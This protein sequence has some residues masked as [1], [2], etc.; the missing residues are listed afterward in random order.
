MPNDDFYTYELPAAER[1]AMLRRA[2]EA[3]GET[4]EQV[5]AALNIDPEDVLEVEQEAWYMG[6][7]EEE[8][9][10]RYGVELEQFFFGDRDVPVVHRIAFLR[11]ELAMHEQA[12][13]DWQSWSGDLMPEHV[14]AE[15]IDLHHGWAEHLMEEIARRQL[16]LAL[17]PGT[18]IATAADAT[19]A[20]APELP[21]VSLTL[22]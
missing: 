16:E 9:G 8:L 7:P 6:S 10:A 14:A 18:P 4:V 13:L 20:A 19:P 15:W 5:A 1:G 22:R 21:A 12:I 3:H 2:R 11:S 17:L